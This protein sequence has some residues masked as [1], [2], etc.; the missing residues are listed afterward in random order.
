LVPEEKEFTFGKIRTS[1]KN[2][3]RIVNELRKCVLV[4]NRCHTEIHEGLTDVPIDAERFDEKYAVFTEGKRDKCPVCGEMKPRHKKT[5]S[6]VCA[7]KRRR[8]VNW[9]KIDLEDL[10]KEAK[11][12]TVIAKMLGVSDSAVRKR[13][14]KVGLL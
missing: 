2:W 1:P 6:V 4:C 8:K 14:K 3:D 7:G 10:L 11:S 12:Y 9:D 5:C 13:A